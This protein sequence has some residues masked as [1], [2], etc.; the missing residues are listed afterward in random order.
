MVFQRSVIYSP[1][2]IH[3]FVIKCSDKCCKGYFKYYHFHQQL[4]IAFQMV[5]CSNANGFP[6]TPLTIQSAFSSAKTVAG[7]PAFPFVLFPTIF[8][9]SLCMNFAS[10]KRD[11]LESSIRIGYGNQYTAYVTHHLIN[12]SFCSKSCSR[13]EYSESGLMA[14][15]E[16]LIE[17]ISYCKHHTFPFT[18]SVTSHRTAKITK[19]QSHT[20]LKYTRLRNFI[21]SLLVKTY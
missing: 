15:S 11:S 5:H 8:T 6:I 19:V 16:A 20:E 17:C 1:T 4:L 7:M 10:Y 21:I 9:T 14:N 3:P 2:L 18:F 13:K 12:S